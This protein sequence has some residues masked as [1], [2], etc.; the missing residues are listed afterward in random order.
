MYTTGLFIIT[1]Y[2]YWHQILTQPTDDI[3]EDTTDIDIHVHRNH[4]LPFHRTTRLPL[5]IF[6]SL[7]KTVELP[8]PGDHAVVL[9]LAHINANLVQLNVHVDSRNQWTQNHIINA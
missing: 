9:S 2:R 1:I 6:A 3:T 4:L 5:A 8:D 7:L